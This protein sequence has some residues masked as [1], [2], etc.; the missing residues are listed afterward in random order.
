MLRTIIFSMAVLTLASTKLFAQLGLP[1]NLSSPQSLDIVNTGS[2]ILRSNKHDLRLSYEQK[3]EVQKAIG[4]LRKD[5][6][7]FDESIS[8]IPTPE[9]FQVS[10]EWGITRSKEFHQQLVTEI[11]SHQQAKRLN[12]LVL[13]ERLKRI[14]IWGVLASGDI[15]PEV[16]D[17]RVTADQLK[18]IRD[19]EQEVRQFVEEEKW[20][21]GHEYA[22]KEE[23]LKQ[24][25]LEASL[26]PLSKSQREQFFKLIPA[27]IEY[28][29]E[30]WYSR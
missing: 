2:V 20:R 9:R 18:A 21:L 15:V 6:E 5:T 8:H 26:A 28:T 24:Q 13:A 11:L 1:I 25:L 3:V 16:N 4:Q 29:D 27:P 10:H 23:F 17:V 22:R 19:A 7:E 12:Q 30:E 14:G